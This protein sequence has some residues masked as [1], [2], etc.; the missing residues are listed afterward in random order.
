MTDGDFDKWVD[1][2]CPADAAQ[3]DTLLP[4]LANLDPITYDQQRERIAK[5][6]NIRV[7]TL[8]TEVQKLRQR[9]VVGDGGAA[10]FEEVERGSETGDGAALLGHLVETGERLCIVPD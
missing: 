9:E 7:S 5:E 4:D 8:D 2:G 10:A 3:L 6:H 1:S